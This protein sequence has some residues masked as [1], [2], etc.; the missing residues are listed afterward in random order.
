M[1][2]FFNIAL[3]LLAIA[4]I[5]SEKEM[6]GIQIGKE[7]VKLSLF[8]EDMIPYIENPKGATKKMT[9]PHNEFSKVAGYKI[10]IQKSVEF[11][12]TKSELSESESTLTWQLIYNKEGNNIQWGKDSLFNK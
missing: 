8:A 1:P 6:K 4:I 5:Q 11:L 2:L 3:E 12:Y 10:N 9:R 7:V